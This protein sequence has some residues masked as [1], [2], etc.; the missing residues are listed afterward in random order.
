MFNDTSSTHT[1]GRRCNRSHILHPLPNRGLEKK[2]NDFCCFRCV[3]EQ[4]ALTE[5]KLLSFFVSIFVVFYQ[6]S[7]FVPLWHR[8]TQVS[9]KLCS[10]PISTPHKSRMFTVQRPLPMKRFSSRRVG[11][12]DATL[13]HIYRCNCT[14]AHLSSSR[15]KSPEPD[16]AFD[17]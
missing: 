6:L 16:C 11:T 14:T 5:I 7:F 8:L 10:C 2:P 9:S 4:M 13:L 12:C 1:L 3:I 17:G 15:P